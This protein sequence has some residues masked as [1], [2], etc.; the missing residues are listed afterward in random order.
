[1][2]NNSVLKKE[3]VHAI[4]S[5]LKTIGG[6]LMQT[7]YYLIKNIIKERMELPKTIFEKIHDD[8]NSILLNTN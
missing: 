2:I 3:L 1:M 7:V 4:I 8:V 6:N 5:K